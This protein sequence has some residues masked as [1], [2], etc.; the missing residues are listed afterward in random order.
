M[1]TQAQAA[2]LPVTSLKGRDFI[3]L[4][5]IEFCHNLHEAVESADVIYV[6]NWKSLTLSTEEDARIR[7]EIK[8]DWCVSQEHFKRANPGAYYMD[9]MPFIRGE[10]VT[11]EVA[12]GPQSIIYDQAENRLHIQKAILASIV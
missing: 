11:A 3:D 12:D 6:K 2:G 4:R 10:Q 8:N 9:C 1:I 7:E 5:N